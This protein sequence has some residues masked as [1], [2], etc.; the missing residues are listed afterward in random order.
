MFFTHPKVV[1]HETIDEGIDKA[2]CIGEPMAEQEGQSINM[3]SVVGRVDAE[4]R[5]E[6]EQENIQLKR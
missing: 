3:T 2:V 5:D 1:T 4:T 6:E